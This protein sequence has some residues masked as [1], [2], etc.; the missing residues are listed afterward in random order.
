MKYNRVRLESIAHELAPVVVSSE[1][2]EERLAPLYSALRLPRGQLLALTGIRERRMWEPGFLPSDGSLRAARKALAHSEI[3]PSDIDLV[4][5]AGV[6]RDNLEPATACAVA[7]GLGIE[8]DV[9]VLDV[10]NACLG[11]MNA[12]LVAADRLELGRARAALIVSCET[13]REIVDTMIAEMNRTPTMEL[14]KS[15]LATLTGGSGAVALVLAR[16]DLAPDRPRLLGGALRA[17]PRHHAL[18]RWGRDL[19][20]DGAGPQWFETD[21]PAVQRN[22]VA[23]GMETWAAFLREMGWTANDVDRVVTHQV[24][25]Q[26]RDG[27]LNALGLSSEKDFSTFE[28][29]GNMGTVALPATLALADERGFLRE[30]DRVA[31]LGIGSGLNCLM[32][33]WEW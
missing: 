23:L 7:S 27:I 32:L 15:A 4:I 33:G 19:R 2:L 26:H 12:I 1:S 13:S 6:C 9:E 18:C 30:G 5:H 10:S 24:G 22:G 3:A 14:F 25:A 11:A 20:P 28:F 31:T 16:E 29:L 17:A 21:A 8:G